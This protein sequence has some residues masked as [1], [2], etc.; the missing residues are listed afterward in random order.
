MTN[1]LIQWSFNVVTT[2][3][4]QTVVK[5]TNECDLIANQAPMTVFASNHWIL[6]MFGDTTIWATGNDF[7]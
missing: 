4:P 3:L 2:C 1:L 6:T 7:F 5:M